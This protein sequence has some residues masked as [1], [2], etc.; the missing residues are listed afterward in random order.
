MKFKRKDPEMP[1]Q[2]DSSATALSDFTITRVFDAPRELVWKAWTDPTMMAQ[3]WGP[4]S[5][6][7]PVCE[8]DVRVGGRFYI[9]MR[10][11]DGAE[12]PMTGLFRALV[13]PERLEF[14]TAAV[15]NDGNRLLEG[16]T[17]VTFAEQAGKTTLTVTSRA[18]G[19]VPIAPQMLAGME[20][21]WTG[22][23]DKLEALLK[24]I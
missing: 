2:T 18:V 22:S 15:D 11:P 8:M 10:A 21:G 23:I 9:V 17:T 12:Y 16:Q 6:T 13:P 3:W 4:K 19:L 14:T 20:A 7:N 5:F 1:D 24:T